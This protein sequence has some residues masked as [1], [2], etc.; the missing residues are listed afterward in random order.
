MAKISDIMKS[1]E[2]CDLPVFGGNYDRPGYTGLILNS[3]SNHMGADLKLDTL[4]R[5]LDLQLFYREPYKVFGSQF[6]KLTRAQVVK[7]RAWLLS[8]TDCDRG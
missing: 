3:E 4:A 1:L 8:K 6:Y 7:V 5:T 2:T